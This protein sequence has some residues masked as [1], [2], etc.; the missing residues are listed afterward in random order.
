MKI[1]VIGSNLCPDTLFALMQLKERNVDI[2]FRNISTSF[3]DLREYLKLR[4][5]NK[6]YIAVR[7]NNGVGIPYF[8]TENNLETLSL[9]EVLDSLG[10]K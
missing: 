4:E 1:K 5:T 9:D 10:G 7:E 8:L 6:L 2:D 3:A